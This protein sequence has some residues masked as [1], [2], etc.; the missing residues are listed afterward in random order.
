MGFFQTMREKR[1]AYKLAAEVSRLIA[2]VEDPWPNA[3]VIGRQRAEAVG[4]PPSSLGYWAE[5]GAQPAATEL[6]EAA[7]D[8]LVEIGPLAVEP[9]I[10]LVK[11]ASVEYQ[12]RLVESCSPAAAGAVNRLLQDAPVKYLRVSGQDAFER[13]SGGQ[14]ALTRIGK[15]ALPP[16]IAALKDE[17][18]AIREMAASALA[19]IA[20]SEA[21]EPLIA[22]LA[23]E[24][25]PV[26]E[27]A[28]AALQRITQQEFGENPAKWQE[29]W[30]KKGGA[31]SQRMGSSTPVQQVRPAGIDS[32]DR[33]SIVRCPGCGS[34]FRAHDKLAG[35]RVKCPKCSS[36][37]LVGETH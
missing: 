8:R 20:D 21:V 16:L 13:Q 14:R 15:P 10:R 9:L 32:I 29:W 34:K 30:Q 18:H 3:R 37:I 22:S 35:K 4:Y 24:S 5:A 2:E 31:G 12:K 33:R 19:E 11:D 17:H 26:R 6:R 25:E 28:V 23:D 36:V 7:L 27:E 1:A